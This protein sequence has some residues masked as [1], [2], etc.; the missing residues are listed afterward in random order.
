MWCLD[1][2]PQK[3]WQSIHCQRWLLKQT[4]SDA[5]LAQFMTLWHNLW[6]VGTIY[7]ILAQFMTFCHLVFSMCPQNVRPRICLAFSN[8]TVAQFMSDEICHNVF[9]VP[10]KKQISSIDPLTGSLHPSM[11]CCV[12]QKR[13]RVFTR[14][15]L[16]AILFNKVGRCL[17]RYS[18]RAEANNTIPCNT[19]QYNAMTCKTMQYHKMQSNTMQYHTM[20]CNTME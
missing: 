3:N 7:D 5:T 16:F 14:N 8:V 19:I 11:T 2:L 9:W 1:E 18:P 15:I 20:P 12:V 13:S 4:S 10:H 17:A 6:H